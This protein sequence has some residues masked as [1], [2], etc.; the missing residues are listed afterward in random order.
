MGSLCGA[1][2]AVTPSKV[3]LSLW[4]GVLVPLYFAIKPWGF[5][6]R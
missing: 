2:Q 3:I 1:M 5:V 6:E 4:G